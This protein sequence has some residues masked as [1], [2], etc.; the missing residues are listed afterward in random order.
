MHGYDGI[1]YGSSFI[2]VP[3]VLFEAEHYDAPHIIKQRISPRAS[4]STVLVC[5][6]VW[7]MNGY[8]MAVVLVHCPHG[9]L[10]WMNY[11]IEGS[12]TVIDQ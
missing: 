6:C 7:S 9:S 12:Y 8:A 5:A 1:I 3:N 10:T 2:L 11:D 4:Y